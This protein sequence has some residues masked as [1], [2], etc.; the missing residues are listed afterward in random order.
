MNDQLASL[1]Q[2]EPV[3]E[4]AD[5]QPKITPESLKALNP[6]IINERSFKNSGAS[7]YRVYT[8]PGEFNMVEADSA[9]EAFAKS[10]LDRVFKIERENFYRYVSLD[11]DLLEEKE[12][13]GVTMDTHLPDPEEMHT[14][15]TAALSDLAE[16]PTIEEQFEGLTLGDLNKGGAAKVEASAEDAAPVKEEPAP[17]QETAEAVAA[18]TPVEAATEPEA[19]LGEELSSDAVDALLNPEG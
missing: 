15:L 2:E 4:A 11:A 18:E 17:A 9:H 5:A 10:G 1:M 3:A 13:D 14:L 16:I 7:L 6:I 12:G 8:A 19:E